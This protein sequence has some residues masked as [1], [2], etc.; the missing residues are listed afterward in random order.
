MNSIS[1]MPPGLS[2]TLNPLR[3]SMCLSIFFLLI[4]RCSGHPAQ[5][6]PCGKPEV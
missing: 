4:A 6:R 2:F 1:R 5:K 3:R